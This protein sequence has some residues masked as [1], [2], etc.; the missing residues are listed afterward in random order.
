MDQLASVADE[1]TELSQRRWRHP[2]LGQASHAK[3]V[4]EVGG[5]PLGRSSPGGSP[6]CCRG[7]GRGARC[8]RTPGSRRPPVPPIGRLHD[9]FGVLTG[10]GQLGGQGHRIVVDPHVTRVSP[11]SSRRTITRR[12]RCRSMPTYCCWCSTG[13]SFCRFRTGFATPSVLRTPGSGRREDSRR[14]F[15]LDRLD[16]ATLFVGTGSFLMLGARAGTP[17]ETRH[18]GAA[19]RSFITSTRPPAAVG[20]ANRRNL[21]PMEDALGPD[22]PAGGGGADDQL[23]DEE[24]ADDQSAERYVIGARLSDSGSVHTFSATDRWLDRPVVLVVDT[25]S[26]GRTLDSICQAMAGV[27]SP[28]LVDIYDRGGNATERFVVCEHPMSTVASLVQEPEQSLWNEGWAIDIAKQ[29]AVALSDLRSGGVETSGLHLGYIGIDESGRVRLSPW[30]LAEPPG[31][32]S[33]A[34]S[35]DRELVASVLESGAHA[36]GSSVSSTTADLVARPHLRSG[37]G[38]PLTLDQLPGAMTGLGVSVL[39]K[40][41]GEV[42]VTLSQDVQSLVNRRPRHW[43]RWSLAVGAG[44]AGLAAFLAISSGSSNAPAPAAATTNAARTCGAKTKACPPSAVSNSPSATIAP[45]T[46]VTTSAAPPANASG[47]GAVPPVH[48]T[49]PAAPPAT[50]TTTTTT[51]DT[52]PSTTTTTTTTTTAASP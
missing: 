24:G 26:G 42:P 48:T 47:A 13:V 17:T 31:D 10:L 7:G 22:Q 46:P 51:T 50:I 44:L 9:H 3:Q 35:S 40:P 23:A 6:N 11:P 49:P 38:S 4:D 27:Q 12:L 52:S 30:P 18:A 37:G 25:E 8:H 16:L 43:A 14:A 1:L 34:P 33:L 32:G 2:A 21:I 20:T 15:G 29:L 28:Y 41:T 45:V 19:L 36:F 39:D 5:I